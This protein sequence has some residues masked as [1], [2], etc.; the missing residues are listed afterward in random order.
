M[1]M[2]P[3][4]IVTSSGD[5]VSASRRGYVLTAGVLIIM[6][7]ERLWTATSSS[8]RYV[9]RRLRS[10]READAEAEVSGSRHLASPRLG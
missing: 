6:M 5:V 7:A 8:S 4:R 2:N 10:G 9:G 1:E 3:A